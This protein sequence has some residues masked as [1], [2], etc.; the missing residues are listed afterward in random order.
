MSPPPS[1]TEDW[2]WDWDA[3]F[4]AARD[5]GH[6]FAERE[7]LGHDADDHED[8]D[9][10]PSFPAGGPEDREPDD[11]RLDERDFRTNRKGAGPSPF[12][13]R[14]PGRCSNCPKGINVGQLI[15]KSSKGWCHAACPPE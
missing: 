8:R 13:A 12:K 7:V 6:E 11:L 14:F 3:G 5:H 10:G 2:D 1:D 15:I 4:D 9:S